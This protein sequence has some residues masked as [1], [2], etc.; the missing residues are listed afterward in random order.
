M[1]EY[2]L[3]R[4]EKSIGPDFNQVAS[5]LQQHVDITVIDSV[6]NTMASSFLVETN[7]KQIDLLKEQ[8]NGWNI[9]PNLKY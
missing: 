9:F 5:L 8:L 1:S 7:D 2:I 3:F 4:A 6:D